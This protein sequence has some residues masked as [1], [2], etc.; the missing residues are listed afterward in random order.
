MSCFDIFVA[1][2]NKWQ[3]LLAGLIALGAAILALR[4]VYKQLA[5]MR[6]QNNVMVRST[7]GEMISQLDAHRDRVREIVAQRLTSVNT[8]LH[9][10]KGYGMPKDMGMWASDQQ[11]EFNGADHELKALFAM[12]Y[13]VKFVEEKKAAL[14][15]AVAELSGTFWDIYKPDYASHFPEEFNWTDEEWAAAGTRANE[16][17]QE[18][19]PK[20]DAVSR[21][22]FE[23]N[24]AYS[25][26]RRA[27]VRR[28]RIIDDGLLA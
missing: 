15:V 17:E 11:K 18:V 26:Q 21:A 19:E 20:T 13:D 1:F 2:L 25:A 14:L 23:L 28:L 9:Q 3:T 16:A 6:A 8:A 5:L 10:F 4:P 12:S 7:I 24:E 27:L 22:V